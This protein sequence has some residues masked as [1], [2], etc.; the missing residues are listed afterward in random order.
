MGVKNG[1]CLGG[2]G[3]RKLMIRIIN[4][5]YRNKYLAVKVIS[6]VEIKKKQIHLFNANALN[7]DKAKPPISEYRNAFVLLLLLFLLYFVCM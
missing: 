2:M 5:I 1:L 6:L 4:A 3:S 7:F